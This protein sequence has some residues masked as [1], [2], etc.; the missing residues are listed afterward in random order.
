MKTLKLALVSLLIAVSTSAFA[1]NNESCSSCHMLSSNESATILN[2]DS[3]S[4]KDT[5]VKGMLRNMTQ[6]VREK[7]NDECAGMIIQNMTN[8]VR[9][10]VNS[11]ATE[12]V[13]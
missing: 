5:D 9:Q 2:S 7:M 6:Q 1:G 13:F 12:N 3:A 8:V 10:K 4:L 11:N